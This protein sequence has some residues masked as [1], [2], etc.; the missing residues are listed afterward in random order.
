L[1][2]KL[3]TVELTPLGLFGWPFHVHSG[4]KY[5][6]GKIRSSRRLRGIGTRR[7]ETPAHPAFLAI[8]R[9]PMEAWRRGRMCL[10]A[11]P[12]PAFLNGRWSHREI[13]RWRQPEANEALCEGGSIRHPQLSRPPLDVQQHSRFYTASTRADIPC[14]V[15]RRVSYGT[16]ETGLGDFL[17]AKSAA[18]MLLRCCWHG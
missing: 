15:A 1:D 17:P 9:S 6:L 5:A 11:Y 18:E 14:C 4:E 16:S 2:F 12:E 3:D 13:R 8:C 10:E 7:C